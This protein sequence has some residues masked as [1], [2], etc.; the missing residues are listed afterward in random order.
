MCQLPWDPISNSS[1]EVCS[2]KEK[3]KE[4]HNATIA[5]A[6][7]SAMDAEINNKCLMVHTVKPD[8]GL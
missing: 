6:E 8:F 7:S 2:G 1:L 4:F 3:V 5:M